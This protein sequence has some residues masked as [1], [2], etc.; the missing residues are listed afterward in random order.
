MSK[1]KRKKSNRR[2]GSGSTVKET[3]AFIDCDVAGLLNFRTEKINNGMHMFDSIDFYATDTNQEC[4]EVEGL[5]FEVGIG[6][7]DPDSVVSKHYGTDVYTACI[8]YAVDRAIR[9]NLYLGLAMLG[10]KRPADFVM[11]LSHSEIVERLESRGCFVV[12]K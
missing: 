4:F 2:K 12:Y 11:R 3:F 5:R 9:D 1:R 6:W 8:E 10:Q 7:Y